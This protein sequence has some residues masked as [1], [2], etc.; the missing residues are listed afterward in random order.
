MFLL[1]ASDEIEM[2]LDGLTEAELDLP[3]DDFREQDDF[4]P[5]RSASGA[6]DPTMRAAG[7]RAG[8]FSRSGQ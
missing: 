6:S 1:T 8:R 7:A 2:A 5:A 4:S 3:D